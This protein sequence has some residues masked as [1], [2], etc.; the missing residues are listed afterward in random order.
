MHPEEE[1]TVKVTSTSETDDINNHI[2]KHEQFQRVDNFRMFSKILDESG[3]TNRED[4]YFIKLTN[5]LSKSIGTI[6]TERI[7]AASIGTRKK[8]DIWTY[9]TICNT[10]NTI[11][12]SMSE[13]NTIRQLE[14]VSWKYKN[15]HSVS[16]YN[17]MPCQKSNRESDN[18]LKEDEPQEGKSKRSILSDC[19]EYLT[20]YQEFCGTPQNEYS[21]AALIRVMAQATVQSLWALLYVFINI[22]PIIQMFSFILRFVLDKVLD[23]RR[24]KDLQQATVKFAILVVQLLSVH[25]CLICILSFIVFPII[26][27]AVSIAMKLLTN[28]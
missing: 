24:T 5:S 26:Q 11:E 10:G 4:K 16:V 25:A 19:Q 2:F 8:S 21:F 6:N 28:D 9:K 15:P 7:S 1:K 20:N 13:N 3:C 17:R 14:H 12:S 18:I 22:V 23:I 27:M